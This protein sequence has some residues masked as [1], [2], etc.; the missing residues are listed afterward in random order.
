MDDIIEF[1]NDI[2]NDYYKKAIIENSTLEI[3]RIEALEYINENGVQQGY[4]IQALSKEYK[5]VLTQYDNLDNTDK[6]FELGS[7]IVKRSN[8]T[9]E[10]LLE[11]KPDQLVLFYEMLIKAE[12]SV[13]END[14]KLY[15]ARNLHQFTPLISDMQSEQNT[16]VEEAFYDFISIIRDN[17][18]QIDYLNFIQKKKNDKKITSYQGHTT[19]EL[20]Q[21][22]LDKQKVMDEEKLL[23][24]KT[25]LSIF[26][27]KFISFKKYTDKRGK[28]SK[29]SIQLFIDFVKG[30][31]KEY[32]TKNISELTI[33]DMLE[34]E[35]LLIEIKIRTKA[36]IFNNVTLFDL[37][38]MRL[39]DGT[40]RMSEETVNGIESYIKDFWLYI[41]KHHKNAQIDRDLISIL[42]CKSALR[43]KK[44]DNNE[45]TAYLRSFA[46]SEINIFIEKVYSI[47]KLKKILLSS[48]RNFWLFI[49]GLLTGM[50]HE[51][52]LLIN[53]DDI[54]MQIKDDKKYYYIYLNEDQKY[55]HLKNRNAHRN[56]PITDL[57]ISLGFL[58]YV[59]KRKNSGY[60]SLFYFTKT[61][62][63]ASNAFYQRHLQALF[64]DVIFN[65][66]NKNKGLI[67]S[68]IQYRSLRKNFSN[69]LFEET[70]TKSD[71]DENK[72][73]LMG[74]TMGGQK[75]RYLG[76][77]E[78]FK[79][80]NIMN[81]ID[82]ENEI[83]F[84]IIK[85]TTSNFYS[86]TTDLDWISEE[87]KWNKNSKVKPKRGRKV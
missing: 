84:N 79:A 60:D 46:I 78:P 74:H 7:K 67:E 70:L 22:M 29:R 52:S 81:A 85:E 82:F 61:G 6:T 75:G 28:A 83:N 50:R 69:F 32:K 77:L 4:G 38:E 59:K 51:E 30:N 10:Q 63:S 71:T 24:T 76:R 58:D 41:A 44:E 12:K 49:L 2:T 68:Y 45:T 56:I 72:H 25:D 55:Q 26:V 14:I 86:N 37:V 31:G 43:E 34:F 65:N 57:L 64:P 3:K 39:E 80:F 47:K 42:N 5:T 17:K 21:L 33:D 11:I 48:P 9:K 13:L 1:I 18:S 73:R 87:F 53:I 40:A 54:K 36:K 62:A 15:I 35:Q 8:I 23:N 19:E 66:E 20:L 16:K 27:D